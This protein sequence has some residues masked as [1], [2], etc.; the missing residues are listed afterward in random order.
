MTDRLCWIMQT[1][2]LLHPEIPHCETLIRILRL[3][4]VAEY[5]LLEVRNISSVAGA[6][7]VICLLGSRAAEQGLSTLTQPLVVKWRREAP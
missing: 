4:F 7:R 1:E 5:P 6:R 3:L 2:T